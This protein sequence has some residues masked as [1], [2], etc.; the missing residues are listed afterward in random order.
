MNDRNRGIRL[1]GRR[2]FLR[3]APGVGL[4]LPLLETFAPR[5]AGAAPPSFRYAIFM[6]Q[7]NGVQQGRYQMEPDR[8]WPTKLGALT[9][10]GMKA[11]G[12]Q[13]VNVLADYAAKLL[14]VRGC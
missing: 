2:I 6:R 3:G 5:S 1:I 12:D 11:D 8:F 4:G 10:D 9:T 14:I 13:A 7:A